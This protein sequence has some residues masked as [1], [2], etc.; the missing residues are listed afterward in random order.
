MHEYIVGCLYAIELGY[1]SCYERGQGGAGQFSLLVEG[2]E[3]QPAGL[4][5]LGESGVAV[6]SHDVPGLQELHC[7][8]NK[9]V[10]GSDHHA[11]TLD[12]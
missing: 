5:T 11:A 3:T 7:N 10:I 12:L 6:T 8:N 4:G 1:I 9:P 2:V